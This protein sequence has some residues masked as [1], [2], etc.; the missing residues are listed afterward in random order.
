[1]KSLNW[2]AILAVIVILGIVGLLYTTDMGR[3]YL[4]DIRTIMGNFISILAKTPQGSGFQVEV[5]ANKNP[6]YGVS[7]KVV[8]SSFEGSGVYQSMTIS[9]LDVTLNSDKKVDVAAA[10]FSGQ[11]DYTSDGIVRLTGTASRVV[12]GDR[13]YSSA[14]P[15]KISLELVPF[16]FDISN[17]N[18]GKMAFSG[19]SGSVK[20]SAGQAQLELSKL[21]ISNFMGNMSLSEDEKV[22]LG[23]T[24]S[25]IVGDRFSFT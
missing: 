11:F 16:S 14:K 3:G 22:K 1:V 21:E 10:D 23:G 8:N 2:K 12:V 15:T 9:D 13:S 4:D 18:V 25:S 20:S 7:Y 24:A 6:F 19:V 5:E 17:L